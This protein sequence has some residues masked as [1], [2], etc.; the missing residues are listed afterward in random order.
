MRLRLPL[1][2]RLDQGGVHVTWTDG[3]AGDAVF[4]SLQRR[5]LGQA[6]HAVL[7]G[8][9]GR[10][11]GRGHQTVCRGDINDAAPLVLKHRG[12]SE[13]R[14]VERGRQV[15]GEDGVP[16]FGREVLRRGDML[17]AGIVDQDVEP[18]G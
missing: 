1:D 2:L 3:V 10:F 13:P 6:D 9:V 5:D 14:G 11:E 12:Q 8:D 18:A 15:D 7:G 16:L 17:D 4:G